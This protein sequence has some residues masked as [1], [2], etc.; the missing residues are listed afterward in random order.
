MKSPLSPKAIQKLRK[1]IETFRTERFQA[2][3][4]TALGMIERGEISADKL[5]MIH[6]FVEYGPGYEELGSHG[7]NKCL[8]GKEVDDCF[9][10][11]DDF[12]FFSSDTGHG[13]SVAIRDA[14]EQVMRVRDC[15]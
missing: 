1:Q 14:W 15:D 11:D 12:D 3:Y 13:A 2:G 9:E 4:N 8:A 7:L 5:E 10:E 6:S